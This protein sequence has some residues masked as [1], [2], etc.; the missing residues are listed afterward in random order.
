MKKKYVWLLVVLLVILIVGVSFTAMAYTS[1]K[2]SCAKIK[3]ATGCFLSACKWAVI[4]DS[5]CPPKEVCFWAGEVV[6]G[7]VPINT[8]DFYDK[9]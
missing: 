8:P 5:T 2:E 6:R 7:C 9:K 3:T 1:T 4:E